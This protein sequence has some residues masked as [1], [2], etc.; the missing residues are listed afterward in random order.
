MQNHR[1]RRWPFVVLCLM[2]CA[3][4]TG[5]SAALGDM[6]TALYGTICSTNRP[7]E[8]GG[9]WLGAVGGLTGSVAWCILLVNVAVGKIRRTGR[10][11]PK[12]I[13]WG[14]L[15]GHGAGL[16]ACVILH[17]GLMWL[18]KKQW[19]EEGALWALGASAVVGL[20]LGALCGLLAWGA[21][22]LALPKVPPPPSPPD[23]GGGTDR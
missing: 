13:V 7:V 12:L 11:S 22:A 19:S 10:A 15:A 20:T 2:V 14:T 9:P 8:A 23:P 6:A 21:S 4:A 5:G 1:I 3:V 18:N 17:G 16:I